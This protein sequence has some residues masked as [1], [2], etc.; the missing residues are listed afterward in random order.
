MEIVNVME[1]V[2]EVVLERDNAVAIGSNEV[3]VLKEVAIGDN[4]V[5]EVVNAAA[6]AVAA[7]SNAGDGMPKKVQP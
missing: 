2:T 3:V 4:V 1:I 5:V 6:N 7:T